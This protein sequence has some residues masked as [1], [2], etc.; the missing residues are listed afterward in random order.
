CEK[1]RL[2]MSRRTHRA[3]AAD[4]VPNRSVLVLLVGYLE[5]VGQRELGPAGHSTCAPSGRLPSR[6]I[7]FVVCP[8][9]DGAISRRPAPRGFLL[10]AA[11]NHETD[12]LTA[13]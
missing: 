3:G 5:D 10:R 1:A 7:S 13:S 6:H 12:R 2:R 4:I 8:D 11:I 9:F